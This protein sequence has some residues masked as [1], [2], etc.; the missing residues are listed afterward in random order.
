MKCK[1]C[2]NIMKPNQFKGTTSIFWTCDCGY[3]EKWIGIN[4]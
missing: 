1:K 4:G 3:I 2:G